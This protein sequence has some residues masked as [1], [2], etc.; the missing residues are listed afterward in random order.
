MPSAAKTVGK[1][2]LFRTLG[3]GA[4]GKVKY[5]VNKELNEPVAIKILDKEKIQKQN[6]GA[7]I[8]KEIM[9][10]RMIT[11]KNVIAVKD[12]FA[13]SSKIF[14]VVELVEGGEL[15][16]HLVDRTVLPEDEA[17]FFFH[18]LV[19][20]LM[21]CHSAGIC[22]R[23]LKPENLLLDSNGNLKIS[24]FGLSTLYVGDADAEGNQRAELLHTT[25]GTPNYVAPEVLESRGYDGKKADVWSVGV[26]LFVLLAGYLPFE[27]KTMPALFSKIK[28]ADFA[29]PM[30]F[31]PNARALLSGI[32]VPNPAGRFALVDVF[33]HAWLQGTRSPPSISIKKK[34]G[35]AEEETS[36]SQDGA[37]TLPKPPASSL[38]AT[39]PAATESSSK[40]TAASAKSG[41]PTPPL[42]PSP[43]P[44]AASA[45][46][47]A[48]PL[49]AGGVASQAAPQSQKPAGCL[50]FLC[51]SGAA[52]DVA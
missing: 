46:S 2:D 1:Y 32:L 38:A 16:E 37:E 36:T 29:Y 51:G 4:Y 17:R 12:V 27:E 34:I 35:P 28:R 50:P 40:T 30:W 42:P 6:M 31:S 33:N 18:Q 8:K 49:P 44:T 7:Q 48:S 26:I 19:N 3:E 24:D 52:N 9:I 21:Y 13:T 47:P 23:D 41:S 39:G 15:F 45:K 25:C 14:I 43:S 11:H 5:A 22:H 20:G 10:M